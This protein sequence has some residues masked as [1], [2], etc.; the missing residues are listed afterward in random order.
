MALLS[1][2]KVN[3]YQLDYTFGNNA[4]WQILARCHMTPGGCQETP[5]GCHMTLFHPITLPPYN[6][7]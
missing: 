3:F 4:V 6:F 1:K 2:F 7:C 5:G